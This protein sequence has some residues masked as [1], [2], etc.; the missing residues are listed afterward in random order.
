[1]HCNLRPPD[2]APVVVLGF[3]YETN[4]ANSTIRHCTHTPN[5]NAIEQSAVE[6]LRFQYDRFRT[7]SHLGFDRKWIFLQFRSLREPRVHRPTKFQQQNWQCFVELLT[8]RRI[9]R[10]VSEGEMVAL[11]SQRWGLNCTK[12]WEEMKLAVINAA[13]I[14]FRFHIHCSISKL[15]CWGRKLRPNFALFDTL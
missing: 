13:R 14:S 12:F 3:N 15:G 11:F 10:P 2:I 6:L 5:F 1:M 8:I 7:V 4:N 9:S